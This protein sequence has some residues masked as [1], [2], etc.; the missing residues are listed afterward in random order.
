[1]TIRSRSREGGRDAGRAGLRPVGHPRITDGRTTGS[2]V[3]DEPSQHGG[4]AG[5]RARS[6]LGPTGSGAGC[7]AP[8]TSAPGNPAR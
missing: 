8:G 6:Q 2:E 7:P 3:T 1:M 5:P 4:P